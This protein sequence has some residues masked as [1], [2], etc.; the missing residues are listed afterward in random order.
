MLFRSV[1]VL[2]QVARDMQAGLKIRMS[3]D[4]DFRAD[5]LVDVLMQDGWNGTPI[6]KTNGWEEIDLGPVSL[7]SGD[8]TI[9]FTCKN[10][11]NLK[12]D[13]FKL[14]PFTSD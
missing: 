8:N 9:R 2:A 4:Q 7:R 10:N 14:E 13:Y 1:S 3:A 5:V 11:V 12:I 6:K